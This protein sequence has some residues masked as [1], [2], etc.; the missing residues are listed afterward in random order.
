MRGGERLAG[1]PVV[2]TT[3]TRGVHTGEPGVVMSEDEDWLLIQWTDQGRYTWVK[4][5]EVEIP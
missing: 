1:R 4:R 2:S 3:S 5:G